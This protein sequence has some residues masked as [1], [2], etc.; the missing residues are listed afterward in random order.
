MY[1]SNCMFWKRVILY[2]YLIY[3]KFNNAIRKSS[4]FYRLIVNSDTYKRNDFVQFE[5]EQINAKDSVI[6]SVTILNFKS[7]KEKVKI[8]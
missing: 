4:I 5:I 2:F 1:H 8:P 6:S 3:R 7:K